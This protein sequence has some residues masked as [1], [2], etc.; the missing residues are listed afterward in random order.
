MAGWALKLGAVIGVTVLS[1]AAGFA[2]GK[3]STPAELH[4]K[5]VTSDPLAA[6][7]TLPST[8]P[9]PSTPT[10]PPST[11]TPV[12]DNTKALRLADLTFHEVKASLQLPKDPPVTSDVTAQVPEG[13]EYTATEGHSDWAIYREP[14]NRRWVRIESGF[15]VRR[16]TTASMAERIDKL[17][18]LSSDQQLKILSN[19]T[20]VE[21][22]DDGQERT[23]ST[24]VYTYLPPQGVST[25]YVIVRWVGFGD[26]QSAV[27]MAV[28]GLPQDSVALEG[29]L[30]KAALS[31]TREDH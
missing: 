9:T 31:V 13:W 27:E 19:V 28:V 10:P 22:G 25:K 6:V 12:P 2:G 16:A 21:K 7:P 26:G 11:R 17:S 24:L 15:T 14:G 5:P 4:P 18:A 8:S 30:D 29:V 20:R 3:L 23:F 1:G